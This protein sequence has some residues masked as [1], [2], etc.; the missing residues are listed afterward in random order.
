MNIALETLLAALVDQNDGELFL[1][2]EYLQRDYDGMLLAIT[3][4]PLRDGLKFELV[5]QDDVT[6][7]D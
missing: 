2:R 1:G 6:Y 7:D 5:E 4:D 3:P